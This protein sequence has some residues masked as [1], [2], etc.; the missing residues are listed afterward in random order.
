MSSALRIGLVAEGV[1]DYEVLFAV[2]SAMLGDRPFVLSLLQPEGSVAFTGAGD[3][4][5]L[6]GGWEGVYHWTQLLRERAG[7]LSSDV[8]LF[9]GHE[10]F[11]MHLDADVAG[12]DPA[13]YVNRTYPELDGVLPCEEPCPPPTATT[14]RL[15]LV[16]VNWLG[17]AAIPPN[18]VLCTPSKSMESWV[19]PI[20]CPADKDAAKAN[21]E[22]RPNPQ[23]RLGQQP[24][25]ERFSKR[26][27]DYSARRDQLRAGWSAIAAKLSEAARFQSDFIAAAAAVPI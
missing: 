12:E 4:G 24:K 7:S 15:R 23:N 21:W 9:V 8:A 27:S 25:A 17:E 5:G 16:M 19:V 22:C 26:Q 14:D 2:I 13:N 10:L 20:C 3:A 11:V 6:G 18:A 1:T